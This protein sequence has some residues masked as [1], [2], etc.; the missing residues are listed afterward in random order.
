MEQVA[1][2]SKNCGKF[3]KFGYTLY[4]CCIQ[5]WNSTA[6]SNNALKFSSDWYLSILELH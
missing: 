3:Q 6:S 5:P 4:P 2:I 1:Q